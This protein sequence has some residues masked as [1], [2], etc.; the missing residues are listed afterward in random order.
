MSPQLQVS[1]QETSQDLPVRF[2]VSLTFCSG[3]ERWRMPLLTLKYIYAFAAY[4][5]QL[6]AAIRSRQ[7]GVV[8]VL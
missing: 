1:L 7:V 2:L 5:L 4:S 8:S 6:Y 3:P